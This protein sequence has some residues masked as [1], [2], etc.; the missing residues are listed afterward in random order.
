M[1]SF[2]PFKGEDNSAASFEK[3]LSQLSQKI[4]K[5][6]ARNEAFRQQQRRYKVLW[7]LYSS[8]AYILIALI[9]T[10]VTGW[11]TWGAAEYTAVAVGPL[12]IY[13][14]RTLLDAY[15]NYR[16]SNS[17]NH[18]NDLTKQREAT[19]Q[20]L[21]TATKYDSTQQLLDKYGGAEKKRQPSPQPP[22]KRKL[23][24]TKMLLG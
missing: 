4:T 10:L 1:V 22:N 15:F 19:I 20:R 7:T 12:L 17:Q 23:E 5:A 9:L 8:F 6:S 16:I 3:T 21:K 2:W 24:G 18:L 11:Q 13:G 14:V